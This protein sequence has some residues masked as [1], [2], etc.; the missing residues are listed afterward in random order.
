MLG[1]FTNLPRN[2]GPSRKGLRSSP[3]PTMQNSRAL[4]GRRPEYWPC[5]WVL[6]RPEH[7]ARGLGGQREP[8]GKQHSQQHLLHFRPPGLL[9]NIPCLPQ[10]QTH[11]VGP[12]TGPA[13][14]SGCGPSTAQSAYAVIEHIHS[15]SDA[16][17]SLLFNMTSLVL[18]CPSG[19]PAHEPPAP[20]QL[21]PDPAIAPAFADQPCKPAAFARAACSFL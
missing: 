14:G 11:S 6:T 5:A 13:Q 17:S 2:I 12:S 7:R 10:G 19:W 1:R 20:G 16:A 3:I 18:V 4:A 21:R 8:Q 15:S 9:S